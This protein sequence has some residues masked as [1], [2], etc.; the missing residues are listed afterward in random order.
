MKKT[1]INL[2]IV[3]FSLSAISHASQMVA[4]RISE[5]TI[6]SNQALVVREGEVH[7]K[8]GLNQL[9]VE[10]TAFRVDENSVSA[11]I[12]G[13]GEMISVQIKAIPLSEFPQE[14]VSTIEQKLRELDRSRKVLLDQKAVL[15]KKSAFIDGLLDFS[16]TQ[17]P[18]DV[19]TQFPN[20][21][22]IRETLTFI[23]TSA[24]MIH[25]EN[26]TLDLA[27][28]EVNLEIARLRKELASLKGSSSASKQAIEIL[29]NAEN[30]ETA[31]L[32]VQYLVMQAHWQ[33]Q[34]K[35]DVPLDLAQPDLTMFARMSQKSGED[36]QNI[37]LSVSNVIPLKGVGVPIATPW[38][39]DLPRPAPLAL[40]KSQTSEMVSVQ[41][42][43]AEDPSPEKEELAAG[44][45]PAQA[46]ELPF[47]F[48]YRMPYK[49]DIESRDQFSILPIF[50]KRLKTD[51]FHYCIPGKSGLTYLIAEASADKEILEG[52]LNVYLGGRYIGETYLTEKKSG[53]PFAMNLGA[54]RGVKV[55]RNK[56]KDN[57]KESFFGTIQRSTTV[58]SF[59]Y[60]INVESIRDNPVRLQV[61]D[62]VPVSRTDKITVKDI[63]L[64]P[65]PTINDYQDRAGVHLWELELLPGETREILIDFTVTYPTE[66]PPAGL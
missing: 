56:L 64:K 46:T 7:L 24:T 54:D 9:L 11:Q 6:F 37:T 39:L 43:R 13:K 49:V 27:I 19:Q 48:E 40:S 42:Y 5:V 12:F 47:S 25:T 33:P 29:F 55:V 59:S 31:R 26:Q 3:F 21:E 32:N 52:K 60:K 2:C 38:K 63:R 28:E 10:T 8:P 35:I 20:M 53:E 14:Q 15:D 4:S 50:T 23:G 1:I 36:W 45:A 16:K 41:Y 51:Y 61:I 22:D 66:T 58:R 65:T 62:R 18:K 17:I 44:Y 30:A 34:Y 57:I